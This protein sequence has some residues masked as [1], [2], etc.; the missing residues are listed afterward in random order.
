MQKLVN[1]VHDVAGQIL[2][3]FARAHA[4]LVTVPTP[5]YV[6][7][8]RPKDTGKV[9]LISGGGSGHEPLHIGFVGE[10]LLD[11]AIPGRIFTSPTPDAIADAAASVDTGAGV[12]MIVKNYSGD[13]MNF[14]LAEELLLAEGVDVRTVVVADDIAMPQDV[15][16]AGRRGV[17]GT[18]LV[19]K[20]AG[21][22]AERGD[23]LDEVAVRARHTAENV[24]SMGVALRPGT[25]PYVGRPSYDLAEGD[26]EF[27]IGIHGEP[28]CR[29]EKMTDADAL[30]DELYSRL[31]DDFGTLGEHRVI[32]L[33]NGMG[34][35]PDSELYICYRRLA[36]LL[37]RDGVE[38]AHALVGSYVTSMDTAGVSISLLRAD[39]EC[40]ELFEAPAYAPY[41]R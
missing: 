41:W 24:R 37:D 16:S 40:V 33:V 36:E 8:R 27:G 15:P 32:A 10:G 11:A 38:C 1:D 5:A 29:R 14:A 20:I 3:G 28:G 21:A 31:I 9:A 7:R 25:V 22:A 2:E 30:V 19:E 17:A 35:T 34:A 12:V 26:V 13:V 23:S 6:I 4:G 18:V 39:D